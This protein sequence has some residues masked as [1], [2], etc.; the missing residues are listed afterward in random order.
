MI[1][2]FP[3]YFLVLEGGEYILMII[4]SNDKNEYCMAA[5]SCLKISAQNFF[6][7]ALNCSLEFLCDFIW[8]NK[9]YALKKSATCFQKESIFNTDP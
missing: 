2:L 9:M 6:P 1:I 7:S 5:I 8:E 4:S 3:A